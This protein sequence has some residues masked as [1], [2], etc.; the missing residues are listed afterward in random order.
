MPPSVARRQLPNAAAH[1]TN[2]RHISGHRGCF[3]DMCCTNGTHRTMALTNKTLNYLAFSTYLLTPQFSLQQGNT[4]LAPVGATPC[5][6]HG[7]SLGGDG[8]P[9][10]TASS[11]APQ[12]TGRAQRGHSLWHPLYVFQARGPAIPP[13]PHRSLRVRLAGGASVGHTGRVETWPSG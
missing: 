4:K 8:T 5:P 2:H 6:N 10:P 3:S 12:E 11:R 13:P 9:I 7:P 1:A